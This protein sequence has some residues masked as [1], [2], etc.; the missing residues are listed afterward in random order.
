MKATLPN[1]FSNTMNSS[2]RISLWPISIICFFTVAIIGCVTFV[3]FCSRHPADLISANYYED[4]VKYQGQI[5]RL[6]H[7]QEHAPAASVQYDKQTRSITVSVPAEMAS[8]R[9]SGQIQLYRPS[10]LN[11]DRTIK[12]ELT[13]QGLQT[14]DAANLLPGLWKVRVSW[15][16][17]DRQFFMDQ[18]VVIPSAVL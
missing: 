17:A 11:L 14:I 3:A 2:S 7:T 12:L 15:T 16:V 1:H 6:Q 18:K 13:A 4:E 8:A 5:D 10:A 9:P